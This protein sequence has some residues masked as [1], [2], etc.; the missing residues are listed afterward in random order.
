M[1]KLPC[2]LSS[3]PLPMSPSCPEPFTRPIYLNCLSPAAGHTL[4]NSSQKSSGPHYRH[5][6]NYFLYLTMWNEAKWVCRFTLFHEPPRDTLQW[7]GPNF[8]MKRFCVMF[9][10]SEHTTFLGAGCVCLGWKHLC[11]FGSRT[12]PVAMEMWVSA[13][14]CGCVLAAVAGEFEYLW[15]CLAKATFIIIRLMCTPEMLSQTT[16]RALTESKGGA[17]S[18]GGE[19]T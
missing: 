13:M 9:S 15:A 7:Y 4:R 2:T 1:K 18:A 8:H 17:L 12:A 3:E 5:Y 10:Q 16:Q 6:Y 11:V 19:V 14:L